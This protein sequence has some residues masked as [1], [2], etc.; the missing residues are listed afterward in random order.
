MNKSKTILN[1]LILSI[2][3]WVA[4]LLFYTD[5]ISF[6]SI[7]NGS[8][9]IEV[10]N[11]HPQYDDGIYF[12]LA[13]E[14]SDYVNVKV[15]VHDR[16]IEDVQVL[17]YASE[18]E[19]AEKIIK[20]F[21][22]LIVM[23]NSPDIEGETLDSRPLIE[24]IKASVRQALEQ[25]AAIDQQ[26]T[27]T[28]TEVTEDETTKVIE[29][30]EETEETSNVEETSAESTSL[31]ATNETNEITEE[32]S[33]EED[34]L[35]TTIEPETTISNGKYTGK[36]KKDDPKIE[37]EVTLKDAQIKSIKFLNINSDQMAKN[38]TYQLISQSI[39][40][41]NST[42]LNLNQPTSLAEAIIEAVEDA[43]NQS[44]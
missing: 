9:I 15:S 3:L 27:P 10:I 23:A 24:L 18:A 13:K 39:I 11:N 5:K 12:G 38:K 42:Q 34:D 8:D 35:A 41:S 2:I 44:R 7:D 1:V 31:E 16:Q 33:S 20:H 4:T 36:S 21:P 22:S 32:E 6:K 19:D 25:P 28:T 40:N 14:D 29:K 17:D 43:I 30:T 26:V 37:V